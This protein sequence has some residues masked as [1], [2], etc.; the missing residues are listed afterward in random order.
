M[1][2]S[3]D[4]PASVFAA[5]GDVVRL[6]LVSRLSKG[7]ELSITQLSD[8]LSLTR[9]GVT[10]HLHV[11]SEAGLVSQEQV[12]RE[13]RFAINAGS[14]SSAQDYLNRASAQWDAAIARLQLK[15]ED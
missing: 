14:I 12:G 10:K 9:Q 11:L 8:G 6:E 1:L 15:L 5:L 2:A 3:K 7:E 13:K 4:N